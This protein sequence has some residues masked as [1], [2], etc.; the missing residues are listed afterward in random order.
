MKT[1]LH[2]TFILLI[3]TLT[4]C[5]KED[6]TTISTDDQT[7]QPPPRHLYFNEMNKCHQQRMSKREILINKML[8]RWQWFRSQ[9]YTYHGDM[10]L[11]STSH[12][13]LQLNFLDE[14]ILVFKDQYA[15]T[16]LWGFKSFSL[17]QCK[18]FTKDQNNT[19]L[20]GDLFFCQ[21]QILVS[22]GSRDEP[23]LN[24]YYK[25]E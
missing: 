16:L 20:N 8:G 2:L 3:L 1:Y 11:D 25:I 24:W 13:Q 22:S 12:K 17:S 23:I 5:K 10:Y 7:T 15:D 21:N 6:K 9:T 19:F 14:E 18:I 4:A